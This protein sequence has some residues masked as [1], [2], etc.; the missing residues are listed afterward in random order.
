M[1]SIFFFQD[2]SGNQPTGP[3]SGILIPEPP[4]NFVREKW[5][6]KVTLLTTAQSTTTPPTLHILSW[7]TFG[8]LHTIHESSLEA[9]HIPSQHSSLSHHP[10]IFIFGTIHQE[11][12]RVVSGV[13]FFGK[14]IFGVSLLG[15]KVFHF[16]RPSL[17]SSTIKGLLGYGTWLSSSAHVDTIFFFYRCLHFIYFFHLCTDIRGRSPF[18]FLYKSSLHHLVPQPFFFMLRYSFLSFLF[19]S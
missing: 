3:R 18:L 19:C 17:L 6:E 8:T 1:K 16:H 2:S 4:W 10:F 5:T 14:S 7:T 15:I 12:G 11:N 9:Y 13:F